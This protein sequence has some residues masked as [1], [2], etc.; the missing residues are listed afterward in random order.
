MVRQE[1]TLGAD[2]E[3]HQTRG[4]RPIA[5]E[6]SSSEMNEQHDAHALLDGPATVTVQTR[7]A[8]HWHCPRR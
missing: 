8:R 5:F 4:Q 3:R 1:A 7:E 2:S 6:K